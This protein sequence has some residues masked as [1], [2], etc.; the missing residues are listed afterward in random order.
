MKEFVKSGS[1]PITKLKNIAQKLNICIVLKRNEKD[2][3]YY[4]NKE[5]KQYKIN[6]IDNHYFLDCK[7]DITS[8]ALKNYDEIKDIKD[9]HKINKKR[10]ARGSRM[11]KITYEK[12]NKH[13]INSFRVVNYLLE[14]K[15]RLLKSIPI[16]DIM[17]TPYYSSMIDNNDLEYD[18][19][20][21]S[22][23][24]ECIKTNNKNA[25]RIFFDFETDT[26]RTDEDGQPTKHVPYLMCAID[27]N[28]KKFVAYGE[29]CGKDFINNIKNQFTKEKAI[30]DANKFDIGKVKDV[31]LIAHNCR[32]DFTFIMDYFSQFGLRPVLNGTRLMGGSARIYIN[33][34]EDRHKCCNKCKN[35]CEKKNKI[36]VN[37]K[38][39]S[40]FIKIILQD[41]YNL[42]SK[43]LRDFSGMFKLDSQKEILPYDLYTQKNIF[44]KYISINECLSF[45]KD[46]DKEEYL[47]NAKNWGCIVDNKIDIIKYSKIYCDM[48]CKVLKDGYD[49]FRT[50][51]KDVCDLDIINYCSIASL[52]MDYLIK[53]G[54]F[55]DNINLFPSVTTQQTPIE[56]ENEFLDKRRKDYCWKL[57]GRPRDFIQKCVVGGRT[58]TRNNKKWRVKGR[59]NDNDAVGLY[60]SSMYRMDGFLKGLPKVIK[61][62]N[63][64][65]DWLKNNSDGYF[66]KVMALNDGKFLNFPLLSNTEDDGIRNFTNETKGNIYYLDKTMIEDAMEY[67]NIKFNIICGYYYD[68]GHNNKINSVMEHLFNTRL[69]AKKNG[70]P[71][72]EIYK[73]LMNSSYGKSLLKPIET[74]IIIVPNSKFDNYLNKNYNYIRE[75]TDLKDSK[76]VKETKIIDDHFNNCYAGVE[77][78]SMS[79]RI[80]NEVMCLAEEKDLK[81]YYQDTDSMHIDDKDIAILTKEFKNKYNRDLIGKGMGQFHS[82][83]E[84]RDNNGDKIKDLEI[85]ATKS[86]FLGKKSYFDK[87]EGTNNKNGEI[88]HGEHIRMKG[89]NKEGIQHYADLKGCS[90]EDIY[91]RLYDDDKLWKDVNN[92]T[93]DLLAGGS[94][95]KF[96]YDKDMSVSSCS[97][98]FRSVNFKYEKG[99]L[100]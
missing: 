10:Y 46:E 15:E 69:E 80:M 70:N 85:V 35:K 19:K 54:C 7:I 33:N 56:E 98:F 6:L 76:I 78:L 42:I 27:Q 79:K 100:V 45:V 60:N 71:I 5:D 52:S 2:L 99:I 21:C 61:K 53:E 13:Q 83:F 51:I 40:P 95:V 31:M 92:G 25:H 38:W 72:Q 28:K 86:I 89:I 17:A 58:M 47:L 68:E 48:D 24:N 88:I 82:D 49:T 29:E 32:Y 55:R 30:K 36:L 3:I 14:N 43:P 4:G 26:S 62:E 22:K 16:L 50:W 63:L 20:S 64:N 41:S 73:L 81:I 39:V 91:D 23:I 77:V 1:V 37:G 93:F 74:D 90:I 66:I 65:L 11:G 44:D 67:Q 97:S 18:A 87:L 94:K 96:K 34:H 59:I 12:S 9:Y 75:I 57:A 84:I 8:Y